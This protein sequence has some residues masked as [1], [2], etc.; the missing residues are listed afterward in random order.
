MVILEVKRNLIYLFPIGSMI[1]VIVA[2]IFPIIR[3]KSSPSEFYPFWIWGF[4]YLPIIEMNILDLPHK[5]ISIIILILMFLLVR[6]IFLMRKKSN[7]LDLISNKWQSWGIGILILNIIWIISWIIV[8]P[9]FAPYGFTFELII[10]LPFVGGLLLIFGRIY[11]MRFYE[12]S[13]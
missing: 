8:V 11:F 6:S 13:T 1:S 5:I 3:Y 2:F 4:P 9:F 12:E 7:R 10:I